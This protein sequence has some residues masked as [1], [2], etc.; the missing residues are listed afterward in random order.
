MDRLFGL[1]LPRF[2]QAHDIADLSKPLR[3]IGGYR[4]HCQQRL[5]NAAR[6]QYRYADSLNFGH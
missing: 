1:L 6:N 5:M 4:R 3:H 2:A